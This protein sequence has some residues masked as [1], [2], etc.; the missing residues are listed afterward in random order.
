MEGLAMFSH[1]EKVN[2][3]A[4][5]LKARKSSVLLTLKKKTVSHE[6]PKS[7]GHSNLDEKLDISDLNEIIAI[8]REQNICIAEPGATFAE[9]V[10]AAFKYGLVPFVVPELKTITVG[11][12]VAGC[13]IESTSYKFGGFHDSCLEYEILTA[14]GDV[15]ICTPDNENSLLFQMLHG[16]FGTLGIITRIKFKL[17]PAKQFVKMTYE[18]YK[19]LAE[20]KNAIWQHYTSKDIDFMDGI[21]HSPSEYVL[22]AGNFVDNAPYTHS[23]DWVRVY[24]RSTAKRTEDY[25][26]TP[27]YF[28]R[29]NKGVTNVHPKSLIARILFGWFIN[30][31]ITLNVVNV[32][33]RFLPSGVIPITV[34][35]FIPFSK[36]NAFMDWYEKE[37]NHFP[38][39][40]VP[41]KIVRKYE[42][43]SGQFLE[44]V[45]DELFLD[46][47]IYG[48]HKDNSEC[49]Y[50]IIEEKLME[51]GAIKT[52][53]STNL[54]SEKE[55][56]SIWNR[57]NYDLVK[58]KTDPD[59]IFMN[60]Y[61]KMC[62]TSSKSSV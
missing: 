34:D 47:A 25:L 50:R 22:S 30:S 17:M 52:L 32:F 18:K 9:I 45:K 59:N 6:V 44:N 10:D 61:E 55:F 60:L 35:T 19:N 62:R 40:C 31:N 23:Y 51:L 13:S 49:C 11:G 33:K 1:A 37:L 24:F 46:I 26:K 8:D 43:I 12:A 53:I 39:W 29:Y 28:F 54:Y 56:W 42:W 15:L 2:R 3:I 14:K 7:G 36:M 38:L 27:D 21:I 16:T 48:L 57:K 20:F 5:Q 4:Q 58:Q 41:Y